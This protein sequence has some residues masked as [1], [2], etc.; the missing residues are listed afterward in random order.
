MLRRVRKILIIITNNNKA[1]LVHINGKDHQ[2]KDD[3]D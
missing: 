3:N 1:I 2:H